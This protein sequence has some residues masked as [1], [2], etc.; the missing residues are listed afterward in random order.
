[1]FD[2]AVGPVLVSALA[3]A[4]ASGPL[5]AGVPTLLVVLLSAVLDQAGR[6]MLAGSVGEL[7]TVRAPPEVT[8]AAVR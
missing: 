4:A 2:T 7:A 3:S 6:G 1:M 8:A 5:V